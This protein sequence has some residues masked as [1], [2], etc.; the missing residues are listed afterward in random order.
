M[1][2]TLRAAMSPQRGRRTDH[3]MTRFAL[4]RLAAALIVGLAAIL[5]AGG[6]FAES[7]RVTFLL[8]NDIYQMGDQEMADG[9]R[10]GGMASLAAIVKAERA[11]GGH[12]IFAHAGDTLSPSL[13]SGL[14]RGAAMWALT[15]LIRP[16]A[17]TPGNHEFDFGKRVFLQR[18]AEAKFPIFAAN[19]RGPDGQQLP[20]IKDRVMLTFDG[21]RIGLTGET[22]DETPRT[23]SPEDLK[24]LPTVETAKAQTEALR[25][26][27]ADFVVALV[28][29]DRKQD[30]ELVGSRMIDLVL[31]G[32]DHDLLVNFDERNAI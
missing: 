27:G 10:R 8:V 21:V 25:R 17:F 19:L 29:A 24:F 5:L 22:Y 9:K 11:K 26:E 31:S 4:R 30:Q 14:D 6:A 13:M 18:V 1:L 23:S 20:N 12:V 32:H 16:D 28:H 15:N 3:D 7:T 2:S